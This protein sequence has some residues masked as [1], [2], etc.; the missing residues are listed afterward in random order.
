MTGKLFD[1][2]GLCHLH[3]HN[4]VRMLSLMSETSTLTAVKDRRDS[5][6]TPGDR[7]RKSRDHARLSAAAMAMRIGVSRN[8]ITNYET[9]KTATI[10]VEIFNAYS[11]VTGHHFDWLA[12]G[13]G[14]Y[15]SPMPDDEP[16]SVD[17]REREDGTVTIRS[18]WIETHVER[19]LR[20]AA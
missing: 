6:W 4:L 16:A 3:T 14:P 18:P 19:H 12:R 10:P 13:V 15:L 20:P 2:Q 9:G 7:L 1:T 8:T 5:P 17:R 11:D